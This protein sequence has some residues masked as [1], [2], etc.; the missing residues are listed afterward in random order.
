MTKAPV[1]HR[2]TV[3]TQW[4]D[5]NGHMNVAYYVLIF[6]HATDALLDQ[7]GIDEDYREQTGG[8]VFVVESHILYLQEILS[9]TQVEISTHI[10]DVDEKRLHLIHSMYLPDADEPAATI[11]L[12]ILH[13]DLDTRRS[14]PFADRAKSALVQM[15]NDH[16][17]FPRPPQ[18][19][20]QVGIR[21]TR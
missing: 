11:E 17:R 5:Y 10:L 6:D 21:K 20:R 18:S 8:S 2:E 16:T 15:R 14:A 19:G 1:I 7:V 9:G 4:V 12:M 3:Q 13:V